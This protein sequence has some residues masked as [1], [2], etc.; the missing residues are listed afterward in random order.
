MKKIIPL[1]LILLV[2]CS[3]ANNNN[4]NNDNNN[5]NNGNNSSTE[6]LEPDVWTEYDIS[7]LKITLLKSVTSQ[8]LVDGGY[9]LSEYSGSRTFD[10]TYQNNSNATLEYCSITYKTDG[11]VTYSIHSDIS[12]TVITPGSKYKMKGFCS[13]SMTEEE[14]QTSKV[15]ERRFEIRNNDGTKSIIEVE[16]ETQAV[17]LNNVDLDSMVGQ[18]KTGF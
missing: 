11:G 8:D 15:V 4:N 5:S 9:E 17:R 3:P 7:T 2:A 10:A 16:P 13:D 14:Y 12:R 1:L 6:V 18:P